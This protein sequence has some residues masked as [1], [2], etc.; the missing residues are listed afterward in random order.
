MYYTFDPVTKKVT[1]TD[2]PTVWARGYENKNRVVGRCLIGGNYVSTVF[3]GHEHNVFET[4]VL[5]ENK[6]E[7]LGR[8]LYERHYG[9]YQKALHGHL[10]VMWCVLN[11]IPL[12]KE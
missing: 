11:N 8:K 3:V 10:E 5:P 2:D 12:P 9:T 1:W 4:L 7:N 6:K